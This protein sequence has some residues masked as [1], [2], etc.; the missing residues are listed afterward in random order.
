MTIFV[1]HTTPA[2]GCAEI[3]FWSLTHVLLGV[4][5]P[6]ATTMLELPTPGG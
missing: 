3:Q 5:A 1:D 6:D 4:G 2:R